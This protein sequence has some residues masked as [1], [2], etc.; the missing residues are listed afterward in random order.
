MITRKLYSSKGLS[1]Y[2][3]EGG[4][5]KVGKFRQHAC[6]R[7]SFTKL[8]RRGAEFESS[9]QPVILQSLH[10]QQCRSQSRPT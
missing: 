5:Q 1:G 9:E 3:H 4:W 7:S 8:R 2:E 6:V 10:C